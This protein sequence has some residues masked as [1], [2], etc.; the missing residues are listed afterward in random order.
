MKNAFSRFGYTCA[1]VVIGGVLA[2]SALLAGQV[3][4]VTVTLPHS[5]KVGSTVLPS[6]EYTISSMSMADGDEY[7][8][9]RGEHTPVVTLAAQKI[10]A[11][12]EQTNRTQ[13]LFSQDGSDWHFERMFLKGDSI[14]YQFV[15]AK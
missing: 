7:F 6:G 9:V 1:S 5:V 12:D 3:N 14:G 2:A 10:D 8:I 4:R 11:A 13:L 15:N